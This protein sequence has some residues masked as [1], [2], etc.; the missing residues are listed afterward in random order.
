MKRL[1]NCSICDKKLKG[2]Q[3]KF[4]SVSCKNKFHQCYPFQKR[5]GISRKLKFVNLLGGC[6]SICGYKKNLASFAFHHADPK[7]KKFKLDARM[8][9]NRCF[10][11]IE[12]EIKKCILVCQNCHAEL[13]NPDLDLKNL[14]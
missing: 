14:L 10:K 13:H 3:R 9:S 2:R 7:K 6:C 8:L 12:K 5:R 11:R 4:C 1:S